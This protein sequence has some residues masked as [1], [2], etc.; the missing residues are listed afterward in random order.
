[1][2][3]ISILLIVTLLLQSCQTYKVVNYPEI[4]TG[5]TYEIRLNNGQTIKSKCENITEES[6]SV[7]VNNKAMEL[8]KSDIQG[9]KRPKVS[10][11]K[12]VG[13]IAIAAAGAILLLTSVDK[14]SNAE[15]VTPRN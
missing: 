10:V 12:L 2:K 15:Q 6:I 11:L 4:E 7:I 13:G 14:E 1:M 3:N 5:K 9:I 8:P